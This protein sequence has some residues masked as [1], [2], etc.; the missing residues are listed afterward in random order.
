MK[1]FLL[2]FAFFVLAASMTAGVSKKRNL[3]DTYW[4]LEYVSP[5]GVNKTMFLHF[6]KGGIFKDLAH[7][8]SKDDDRW[9]QEKKE[10][11]FSF[12]NRFS[13]YKGTFKGKSKIVGEATNSKDQSWTFSMV[14]SSQAEWSAQEFGH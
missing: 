1:R 2:L 5:T 7:Q 9:T 13:V 11:E 12:N 14:R 8:G 6:M 10:V 4:K 3:T